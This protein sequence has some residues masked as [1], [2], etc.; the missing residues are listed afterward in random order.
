MD[1]GEYGLV[2]SQACPSSMSACCRG[3]ALHLASLNGHTESV[4][5]LLD[6]CADVNAEDNAKCAVCLWPVLN[7]RRLHEPARL[8]GR[9]AGGER[10][11]AMQEHG[12]ALCIK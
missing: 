3:T 1:S 5:A 8:C 2:C 11:C 6:N 10:V 4:K 9:P 7:G 12:T